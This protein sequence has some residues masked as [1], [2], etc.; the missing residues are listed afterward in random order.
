MHETHR[1]PWLS[2]ISEK[3]RNLQCPDYQ[4]LEA[5]ALSQSL[6][7]FFSFSVSPS[8]PPT[9]LSLYYFLSSKKALKFKSTSFDM[10]LDKVMWCQAAPQTFFADP[11]SLT[12]PLCIQFSVK[13]LVHQLSGWMG[14]VSQGRVNCPKNLIPR[15]TASDFS[16]FTGIKSQQ[17]IMMSEDERLL[18]ND[19][20]AE[21]M[22]SHVCPSNHWSGTYVI[23]DNVLTGPQLNYWV[24]E[25]TKLSDVGLA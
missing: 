6:I 11:S 5:N 18:H 12:H 15:T 7:S 2:Q 17:I 4:A 14:P 9:H 8:F 16:L 23:A 1:L 20:L 10:S 22:R 3:P 13:F 24:S 19:P 25:S 21:T